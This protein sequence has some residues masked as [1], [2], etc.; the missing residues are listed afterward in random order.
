MMSKVIAV[1]GKGGTGKSILCA[2][3]IKKLISI[4][5]YK[6]LAIDADPTRGLSR[7]L[8]IEE[9]TRTLE[10]VRNKII[11]VGATGDDEIKYQLIHTLP[12]RILEV[13]NQQ[14]GF[15]IIAMGQPKTTG[16]FCPANTVLRNAIKFLLD[17]F[18]IIII[19]CEA[20]LEQ[21]NRKVIHNVDTLLIITDPSKRGFQTACSLKEMGLK[22]TKAK[23]IGLIVNRVKTKSKILI[24]N[25]KSLDIDIYGFIPEDNNISEFD[26]LGKSLLNLPDET[27]SLKAMDSILK[28]LLGDL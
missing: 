22:Y 25:A 9:V 24:K 27:S 16:C 2:L 23:N 8:G 15:S 11:N 28:H 6:I 1:S 7:T 17:K 4:D 13:L 12:N 3:L 26:M 19:D 10:E 5:K 20:G 21:I 14:D 18:D